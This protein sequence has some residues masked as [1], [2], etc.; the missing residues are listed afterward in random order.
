WWTTFV[1]A[2]QNS[3]KDFWR[4]DANY[5][6]PP[7][8]WKFTTFASSLICRSRDD[9]R[10]RCMCGSWPP[11]GGKP[12]SSARPATMLS[13]PGDRRGS[14]RVRHELPE[15]RMMGNYQVRFGGGRLEKV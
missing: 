6:A 11:I 1:Y 15:S 3:N 10:N 8:M 9:A 5:A 13:T 12:S 7:R 2:V 14:H 4:T